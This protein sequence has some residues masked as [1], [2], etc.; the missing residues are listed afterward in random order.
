MRLRKTE[1]DKISFLKSRLMNRYAVL[2]GIVLVCMCVFIYR[3][4]SWQLVSG[5]NYLEEA[6]KTYVST[7]NLTA[8][9]GEIVDINGKPLAVNKTGYNITFDRTYLQ[10][11]KQNEVIK[12]L[13]RLL[14]QRNEPWVD[15]LPIVINDRGEYEFVAGKEEAIEEL[16]GKNFL[17]LNSYATADMCMQQLIELYDVEGYSPKDTR[18][19]CSV[20]YNM[21][22]KMFSISNPYTFAE[23]ISKDTASIVQENSANLPGVTIKI[24]TVREYTDG[25]L[26]PHLIGT[27]GALTQ[28]EYN[29]LKNEGYAYNDKIGKSGLES[30]FEK[31]LRG[32]DGTKKVE[33]NPDGTVNSDNVTE[34]PVPGNTVFTTLDSNLQKVSNVSLANNVQAAQKAGAAT[35]KSQDGED[36]VAGAAVV[37]NVKDFSILAASSYPGYD[38][39]KYLEDPNY[40][41]ALA[42]DEKNKPLVNRAFSGSFV[43]GSVF[44]PLVAAAALQEGVINLQTRITCNHYYNFFAPSFVPT[45]LGWHGSLNLQRAIQVSCNVFF[46]ETGRLLGIDNIDLYAKQCGLGVKTG[47]EIGE[48]AG[49]LASPSYRTENGGTWQP[50]DVV[51]AAIG[52]SDNAFTPLQLAT[53]CATIAN[54]GTRLKTHLVKKV[55]NYSREQTLSETQPEVVAKTEI[56]QSNLKA[57]QQAMRSVTQSGGTASSVFGNYRISI[58]AKT[59][60]AEN[61]GHSD[62]TVFIA[63]APYENPEIAVAVVLEY[64]SRGMYSMNVAKDIFDAYFYGK[65]V[66]ENGNL[67]MPAQNIVQDSSPEDDQNTSSTNSDTQNSASENTSSQ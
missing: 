31:E 49:I 13:V 29:D 45:C 38:L 17:N 56:S 14:T 54:N 18:D 10:K 4:I 5:E 32:R 16:K 19:I 46:Y 53:Y 47:V 22:R 65:T 36:C 52:Q 9:R 27:I 61:P 26:A 21:T 40:Y 7:V 50:G 34:Q 20:R 43:P 42:T 55:T 12:N 3:L 67:V 59:G 48:S 66:D 62:N 39:S 6:N 64:G 51:Q 33:T 2:L 1:K 35:A 58:A 63:Y 41:S 28:E 15:L 37:L 60:T 44:K 24:T 23:N 30:A 11:D 25:T 57:V 8:A